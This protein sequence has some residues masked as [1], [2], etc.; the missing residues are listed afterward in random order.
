VQGIP[1]GTDAACEQ[2]DI[3]PGTA[4]IGRTEPAYRDCKNEE[5]RR[6]QSRDLPKTFQGRVLAM[7]R[8]SADMSRREL[9]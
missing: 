2:T 5:R 3:G 7:V 8:P 1:H 4:Q 6:R 9:A